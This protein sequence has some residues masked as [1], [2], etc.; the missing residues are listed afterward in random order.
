MY[1]NIKLQPLRGS[2]IVSSSEVNDRYHP[3]GI[4]ITENGCSDP[5]NTEYVS[6]PKQ[7]RYK[8]FEFNQN[9]ESIR[10]GKIWVFPKIGGTPPKWMVKIRENPIRIDDLG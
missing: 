3:S 5:G 10:W 4:L 7:R 2:H 1:K 8:S 9:V 6:W